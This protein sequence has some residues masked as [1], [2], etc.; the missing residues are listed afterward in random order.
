VILCLQRGALARKCRI[1]AAITTEAQRII[2]DDFARI[3][4]EKKITTGPK[5]EKDVINFRNEKL[6]GFERVVEYV[7]VGLLRYRK[8]NGRIASDVLDYETRN[9]PLHEK[10]DKAQKVLQKFLEDKDPEKTDD[11]IKSIQHTGQDE[12]AVITCDGFLINGNRRKM[13]LEK[14]K[15]SEPGGTKYD[16]MKVVILPGQGEPGGPPHF[17]KSKSLKIVTSYKLTESP[18]ITDLIGRCPSREKSKSDTR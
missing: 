9:G 3:I 11:L 5:P 13:A 18:S 17:A 6:D 15:Q 12:P 1:M 10:D 7:P 14:L 2:I 4:R 8:D 16:F